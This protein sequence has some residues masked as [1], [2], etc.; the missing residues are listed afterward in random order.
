MQE[1]SHETSNQTQNEYSIEVTWR[2]A[3]SEGDVRSFD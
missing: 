2:Q 1:G 3:K